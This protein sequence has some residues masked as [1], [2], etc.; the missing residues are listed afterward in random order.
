M[1]LCQAVACTT[2]DSSLLEP[3]MVDASAVGGSGGSLNS[4]TSPA[5]P[6]SSDFTSAGG[7]ASTTSASTSSA[8]TTDGAG[9]SGGTNPEGGSAGEDGGPSTG[10][11]SGGSSSGS[12]T[13]TIAGGGS[14][15]CG[16]S[17]CCPQSDKLEPGQC[18]CETPDT[19]TDGDGTAD[20]LDLCPDDAVKV[21]PGECGCGW[22]DDDTPAS[23]GCLGLKNGLAHRYSFSGE[24][25]DAVDSQGD[26]DA[27]VVGSVLD[28]SG[29]VTLTTGGDPQYVSM[30]SGLV[31]VLSNV[32]FEIWFVWDG[33]AQWTRLIDFG[34]TVEGVVGEP[35]TGD[36]F[37]MMSPNGAPGPSYPY[38]AFN[39]P[40]TDAEVS[41]SGTGALATGVLHHVALSVDAQGDALTLYVDGMLACAKALPYEL[42]VV[43]DVNCWLGRSQFDTDIGF[44]GAIDEFRIYD[45]ALSASQVALSFQAGPDPDFF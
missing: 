34:T 22:R 29:I 31:S 35:G 26:A 30:P 13:G 40:G 17:D 36:S 25:A 9:A 33:G 18:G 19:D 15:G 21:E 32:T 7:A 3:G 6:T 8:S 23:A 16:S 24:G 14:G 38:A 41:C 4:A 28:G 5:S 43:D 39:P 2:Y 45:V 42:S 44:A 37:I 11:G 1:L 27:D 10:G 20:C 12:G